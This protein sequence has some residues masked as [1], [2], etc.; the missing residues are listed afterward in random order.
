MRDDFFAQSGL[1]GYGIDRI[2]L[3]L[4][5]YLRNFID[6]RRERTGVDF[7]RA[8]DHTD[9]QRQRTIANL[10]KAQRRAIVPAVAVEDLPCDGRHFPR[11]ID[12]RLDPVELAGRFQ[13]AQKIL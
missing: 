13:V 3:A 5:P 12:T 7:R 10:S 2:A 11:R 9:H 1:H 8:A 4:L 6:A